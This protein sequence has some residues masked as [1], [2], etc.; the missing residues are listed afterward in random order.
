MDAKRFKSGS[1]SHEEAR[2]SPDSPTGE[3]RVVI[4]NKDFKKGTFDMSLFKP[5]Q[6]LVISRS[7]VKAFDQFADDGEGGYTQKTVTKGPENAYSGATK[8]TDPAG[9]KHSSAAWRGNR[10]GKSHTVLIE[11][12]SGTVVT[13]IE[14]NAGDRVAGRQLDMS[15]KDDKLLP[16]ALLEPSDTMMN[17]MTPAAATKAAD[18]RVGVDPSANAIEFESLKREILAEIDT[19]NTAIEQAESS[20]KAAHEI[21]AAGTK[22]T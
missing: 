12:V 22:A 20:G 3:M 19:L 18:D 21:A 1:R 17:A 11:S 6:M 5:G 14:G 10:G 13:T 9:K 16:I 15:D 7:S 8:N 4:S 2:K